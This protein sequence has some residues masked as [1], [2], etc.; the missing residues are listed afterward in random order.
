MNGIVRFNRAIDKFQLTQ[1]ERAMQ[2]T[3][4]IWQRFRILFSDETWYTLNERNSK[5][6]MQ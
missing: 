5:T 1:T 3:E 2:N 4:L 6:Q